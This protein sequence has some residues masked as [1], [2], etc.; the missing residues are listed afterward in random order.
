MVLFIFRNLQN[1]I[2]DKILIH[3][4]NINV[5]LLNKYFEYSIQNIDLKFI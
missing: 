3:D 2:S 1:F 5:K 4:Q